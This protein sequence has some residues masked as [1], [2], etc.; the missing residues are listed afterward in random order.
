MSE[1]LRARIDAALAPLHGWTTP[2]KGMR[3]AELVE[4]T[5]A[6]LSVEIG[7]FGGRGTIAMAIG[8]Q[9]LGKGRVAGIDPWSAAASLDGA[10]DAANDAW[11]SHIDYDAI[12]EHF[13]AALLSNGVAR[14]CHIMRERSDSAVRLFADNTVSVLHQDGNHSEQ[15]SAAEVELWAPKLAHGGYWVAD[16]ADWATTQLALTKLAAHGFDLL[17]DHGG[18]RVYRKP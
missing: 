1:D 14:Y 16:D 3:L 2:E 7:V 5:R 17:E 10:N 8:H 12:Y 15:I 4:A 11:W 6:D 9:R 13:L 18:W